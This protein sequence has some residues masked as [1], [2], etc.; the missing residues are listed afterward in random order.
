MS[1]LNFLSKNQTLLVLGV[2]NA[3]LIILI[4][5]F[6]GSY[7]TLDSKFFYLKSE[8]QPLLTGLGDEGRAAYLRVNI[9]DFTFII[10]YTLFLFG[11]YTAF[12]KEV[13][14]GLLIIPSLLAMADIC[15]TSIIFYLIKTFPEIHNGAEYA[16]MFLTPMKWLMAL[17]S[18]LVVVNGYFV[19]IYIKKS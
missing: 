15:E 6:K 10:A 19:N 7:E 3:L 5:H 17:S 4:G 16:L 18:L 2:I 1:F 8:I 12:F 11:V 14:G 13:A 9:T